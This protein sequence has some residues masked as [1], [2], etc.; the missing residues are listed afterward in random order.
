MTTLPSERTPE[1]LAADIAREL[2]T[3]E[4]DYAL[5]GAL[6]YGFWGVPRATRD[7]DIALYVDAT[8]VEDVADAV[9]AAGVG[10]DRPALAQSFEEGRAHY[11][12]CGSI[13]VDLFPP[14]IPFE[15]EAA[16]TR[17]RVPF[18]HGEAWVVSA[19]ALC[20][21]KLLFFRPK[22]LVDVSNVI[23]LQDAKLDRTY[24]RRWLVEM[25]GED[26][27]RVWKWDELVRDYS[28]DP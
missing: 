11:A 3:R 13:R 21:F 10:V 8:R 22:D 6:A 15:S 14:S 2:E 23:A 5:S 7:V 28:M 9:E 4:L 18:R 24:V 19:E 25:M 16:K 17:V 12:W 1:T 20:V 27:E 26:D